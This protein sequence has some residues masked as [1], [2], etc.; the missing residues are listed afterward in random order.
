M[1]PMRLSEIVLNYTAYLVTGLLLLA[2]FFVVY[3]RITPHEERHHV[4]NGNTA[5]ALFLSGAMLGFTLTIASGILTH[6]HYVNFVVWIVSA[7][8][9]QILVYAVMNRLIPDL[10]RQLEANNVA[11]GTM[12]GAAALCA[13]MINAACVF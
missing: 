2:L 1:D 5:V 12:G 3:T 10:S 11:V 13:G 4:R 6:V 9:V 8:V 7:L